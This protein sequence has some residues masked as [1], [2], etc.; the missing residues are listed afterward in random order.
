MTGIVRLALLD[1][2]VLDCGR[3]PTE[4]PRAAQRLLAFIGLRRQATRALVVGAL[5]PD[6]DE[7]KAFGSLRTL[8]WRLQQLGAPIV[9]AQGETLRLHD[10]VLVDTDEL[11][12][13][14]RFDSTASATAGI[15]T[16]RDGGMRELLPG[17]YDDWVLIERER[18]RQLYLHTVESLA[19]QDLEARHYSDALEATLAALRVEP[20]RESPHRLLVRIHLAEG[21][22]SEALNVYHAYQSLLH[23]E[24]GVGPSPE[25]RRLLTESLGLDRAPTAG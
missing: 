14:A 5:W 10:W 12:H 1:G 18:L 21:N 2:F 9:S 17:W 3:E 15:A 23:R 22:Y 13:T 6:S 25:M 8:L 19:E 24:L 11:V 4:V 20:L 16:I 7:Q